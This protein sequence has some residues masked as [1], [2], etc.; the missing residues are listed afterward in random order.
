MRRFILDA[1]VALCWYFEDQTA[2]YTEAVFDCLAK[3]EQ[4][5][6]PSVWPLE[7]VNALVVAW[8]HKS[9]SS[10]QL[11]NFIADLKD[12]P[13]EID[14]QDNE[15]AYSSIFRMSCQHR[16]SSYD[17]AYLDLAVLHGLPLA[18]LD[19]NLRSAAKRS[20]VGI[21]DPRKPTAK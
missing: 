4:A 20:K 14:S 16:L 2:A 7:M 8:R 21:F 9:I 19:K 11:E 6:A 12:L 5:L 18:T 15:R 13:V 17:A 1:S 10:E 3:G